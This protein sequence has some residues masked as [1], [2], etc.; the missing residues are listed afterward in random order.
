MS[1][2]QVKS[3]S[4]HFGG[5]QALRG[6]SFEMDNEILGLIGP[7]GAG[8]TT[9]FN[10]ISGFLS[11]SAGEVFYGGKAIHRLHPRQVVELGLART[12]QIVKPF[13]DLTVLDNVLSGFG[14]P[15]YPTAKVFL[16]RYHQPTVVQEAEKLLELSGLTAWERATAGELPIG[17][18][19]RLEI[20]RALA[21]RPRLLLLDEPAAGLVAQEASELASLIRTLYQQEIA[22]IVIE[23]NMSFAMNLCPRILVLVAGELLLDGAPDE[24]RA[25]PQV[26]NAYLGQE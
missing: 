1:A 14:A 11:P 17:L 4:K 25:N 26:I 21:T 24:V 18:Q 13:R 10:V 12:F 16:Q 3:V 20:A 6:I 7:N 22:V 19:R 8:K 15:I 23:H 9:L 2:L 5:L